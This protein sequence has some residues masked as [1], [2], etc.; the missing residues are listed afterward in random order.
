[1]E[2]LLRA[3]VEKAEVLGL[4]VIDGWLDRSQRIKVFALGLLLLFPLHEAI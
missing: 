2:A 4:V 3:C 1:M